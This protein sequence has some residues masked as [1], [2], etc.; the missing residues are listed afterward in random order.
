MK[1][2]DR[3]AGFEALIRIQPRKIACRFLKS[4]FFASDQMVVVARSLTPVDLKI[5]SHH[6]WRH[7]LRAP[8]KHVLRLSAL[9][10]ARPVRTTAKTWQ[11]LVSTPFALPASVDPRWPLVLASPCVARSVILYCPA[12]LFDPN[13]PRRCMDEWTAKCLA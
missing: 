6:A 10:H 1:N 3:P 9:P 2:A 11:P 7:S 4:L 8:Q 13:L 5:L 12:Q